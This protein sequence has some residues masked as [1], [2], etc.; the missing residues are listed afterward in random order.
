[1]DES[2]NFEK[3]ACFTLI[4]GGCIFISGVC[5]IGTILLIPILASPIRGMFEEAGV[6]P[7]K[8]FLGFTE[9]IILFIASIRLL[10]LKEVGRRL[11]VIIFCINIIEYIYNSMADLTSLFTLSTGNLVSVA[12][13][14][15]DVFA[16]IYF[17][18][19][20]VKAYIRSSG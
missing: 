1:M 18:R 2:I 13:F 16:V 3:P 20:N 10:K 5:L 15:F 14:A 8:T 6:T 9:F 12:L 11:I 7:L 17:S 4:R 19:S